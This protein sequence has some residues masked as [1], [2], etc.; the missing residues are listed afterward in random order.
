[1]VPILNRARMVHDYYTILHTQ[2]M[3]LV[4]FPVLDALCLLPFDWIW[5]L[6]YLSAYCTLFATLTMRAFIL[7]LDVGITLTGMD[8]MRIRRIAT[9][10]TGGGSGRA[11]TAGAGA[12]AGAGGRISRSAG[13]GA[14]RWTGA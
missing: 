7:F 6:I 13:R 4:C 2:R 1:M 14:R 10:G 8:Y 9:A 12:C 11:A 5:R 3:G